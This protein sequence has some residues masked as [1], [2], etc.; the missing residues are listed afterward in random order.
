MENYLDV[1]FMPYNYI[2]DADLLPRFGNILSGSILVFDEAHN[3]AEAACEGRSYEMFLA[4]IKGAELE[5]QKIVFAGKKSSGLKNIGKLHNK[6]I[7]ELFDFL[8]D[9]EAT[10]R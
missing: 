2:L 3:V 8:S 9:L 1:F 4:N 7:N 6:L 5:L 10:F